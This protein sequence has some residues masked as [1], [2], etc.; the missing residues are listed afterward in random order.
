MLAADTFT[1]HHVMF[2]EHL[3]QDIECL[4]RDNIAIQYLSPLNVSCI[5][6]TALSPK[7]YFHFTF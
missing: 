4:M 2:T 5:R 1:E 7:A 3:L 6:E